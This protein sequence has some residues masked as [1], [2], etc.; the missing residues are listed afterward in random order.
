MRPTIVLEG[1][2]QAVFSVPLY[3]YVSR[4]HCP[5]IER[6]QVSCG[7]CP[8]IERFQVRSGHCPIFERFQVITRGH[9]PIIERFQVRSGHCPII[10]M[11][12][13][14]TRGSSAGM[15]AYCSGSLILVQEWTGTAVLRTMILMFL[16]QCPNCVILL[17]TIA[18]NCFLFLAIGLYL[19][20]TFMFS[21]VIA[22]FPRCL[23]DSNFDF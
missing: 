3:N 6:F 18:M 1:T 8:T 20:K 9:C 11:F 7:H 10:E 16:K 15:R 12:Q 14:I 13:V 22:T 19:L 23:T 21:R 2:P 4:G 17:T 5:I